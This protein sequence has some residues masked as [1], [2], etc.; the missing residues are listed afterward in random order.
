MSLYEKRVVPTLGGL[1]HTLAPAPSLITTPLKLMF[2]IFLSTWFLG[3]SHY[4]SRRKD[5][6]SIVMTTVDS[7]S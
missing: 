6:S 1:I 7:S 2:H 3:S 4:A 5:L